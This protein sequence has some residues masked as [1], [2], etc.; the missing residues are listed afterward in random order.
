MSE[1]TR[2]RW[3]QNQRAMYWE[4]ADD[5]V[6]RRPLSDW[7]SATEIT[8]AMIG[9]RERW[10]ECGRQMRRTTD[11]LERYNLWHERRCLNEYLSDMRR[12]RVPY[13]PYHKQLTERLHEM[14]E[15][16][17]EQEYERRWKEDNPTSDE[18]W[19]KYLEWLG[20]LDHRRTA[21]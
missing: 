21:V 2:E 10:K 9:I 20:N 12:N 16:A 19:A 14:R 6:S 17:V 8:E 4:G 7:L 18:K 3:E 5:R 11:E 13:G 15:A 1:V